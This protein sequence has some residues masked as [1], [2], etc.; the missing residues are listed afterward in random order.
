MRGPL[1][2]FAVRLS[3][4][5]ERELRKRLAK[6]STPQAEALRISILLLAHERPDWRNQTIADTLG[7]HVKT[8]AK[9]RQRWW[10]QKY[11][12]KGDPWKAVAERPRSGRPR[13]FSP[14][15]AGAG[16]GSGL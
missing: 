4:A 13:R 6:R 9:W 3:K 7:C 8:V 1:P 11:F 16:G 10:Q 5:Q 14:C 12:P 15:G 2:K